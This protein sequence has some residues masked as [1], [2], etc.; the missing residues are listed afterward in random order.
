MNRSRKFSGK[1]VARFPMRKTAH[2]LGFVLALSSPLAFGQTD[3]TPKIGGG[4]SCYNYDTGSFSDITP[5]LGGG[6]NT[7][8]YGTGQFGTITPRLGGGVTID[9]Y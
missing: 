7:Y 3:C 5:R 2:A 9:K 8:D 6:Y 4:Y 1:I